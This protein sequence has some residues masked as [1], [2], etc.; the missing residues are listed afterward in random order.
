MM[1]SELSN[2]DVLC[3]IGYTCYDPRDDDKITCNNGVI[4]IYSDVYRTGS[5]IFTL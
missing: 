1:T 4:Y 5:S 3:R 2:N